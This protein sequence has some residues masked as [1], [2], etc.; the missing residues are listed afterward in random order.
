MQTGP[1]Y[2]SSTASGRNRVDA[3]LRAGIAA[4]QRGD[5][6][7]ARRLLQEVLAANLLRPPWLLLAQ[8]CR[9]DG[10]HTAEDQ[11]LDAL[12][13]HEPRHLAGLLM[14]GDIRAGSGDD[15]G[16]SSFYQA[17]IAQA[18][19]TGQLPSQLLP[20]L[21][22]AEAFV[23]A[24][25]RRYEEHLR[26]EL[27]AGG[28]D[29]GTL[30]GRFAEAIDILTGRARVQLQ[31]PTAFYF[32]GL[33]QRQFFDRSEFDW[34][35]AIEAEADA[36]AAELDAVL[37]AGGEGFAPYIQAEPGRPRSTDPL[38]DDPK[39]SALYLWKSGA[40]VNENAARFPSAMRG[41]AHVPLPVIPGR[42]PMALFSALRP[43]THIMP[44]TGHVNTRLICHLPL[45]VPTGCRFR[46]G[47]FTRAWE[48][49][50]LLIF[51]DTV[52]H[53][54]WND[55]TAIRVVLLFEVWRPELSEEE[56]QALTI[57]YRSINLYGADI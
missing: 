52:E 32:P 15:R 16:A 10:D 23:Q 49:G 38:F 6:R 36:M 40:P 29:P 24:S 56:R 17:A 1:R 51:D 4:L 34:A 31:Q 3:L 53:E 41:L 57:L 47:N 2:P 26:G 11:A 19:T 55:G 13:A 42:A 25:S 46:V 30:G 54:A 18:Q 37:G 5:G 7:E 50:K 28:A 35:S 12:L 14:K 27:A 20:E 39:W 22:R 45:I 21:Q 8:A 48:R 44:H 9:L 43:G 33:A